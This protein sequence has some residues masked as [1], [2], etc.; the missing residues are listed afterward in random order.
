VAC[1][2]APKTWGP[3]L[4]SLMAMAD[5]LVPA[6]PKLPF[7]RLVTA[8]LSLGQWAPHSGPEGPSVEGGANIG[9]WVGVRAALSPQIPES[10]GWQRAWRQG[11]RRASGP[12][13]LAFSSLLKGSSGAIPG[14]ASLRAVLVAAVSSSLITQLC[15]GDEPIF[16][17]PAYEVRSLLELPL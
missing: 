2:N 10:S 11:W 17:L 5:G 9:L 3:G 4:P 13:S 7:L 8:A 1:V 14:R 12:R 6:A 16:R 15:L